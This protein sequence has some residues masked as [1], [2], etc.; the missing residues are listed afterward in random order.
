LLRLDS[1]GSEAVLTIEALADMAG[2]TP[3]VVLAAVERDELP[4]PF[5]LLGRMV[6]I[7]GQLA[8]FFEARA[9]GEQVEK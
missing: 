3:D 6:W 8:D 1:Y 9:T 7:Q 4:R 2:T 5:G